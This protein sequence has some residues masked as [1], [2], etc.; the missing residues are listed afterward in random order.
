MRSIIVLAL[1]IMLFAEISCAPTRSGNKMIAFK[2]D[3]QSIKYRAAHHTQP[4]TRVISGI[5]KDNDSNAPL[6][7]VTITLYPGEHL[8]EPMITTMSS[9]MGR[10]SLKVIDGNY[11]IVLSHTRFREEKITARVHGFDLNLNDLRL[12]SLF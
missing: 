11:T 5:V 1:A 12:T 9:L 8:T 2:P 3:R 4:P 6:E 10:F 7:H